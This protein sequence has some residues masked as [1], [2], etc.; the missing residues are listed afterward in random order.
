MLTELEQLLNWPIEVPLMPISEL[1]GY[2][3]TPL[4]GWVA[5]TDH[6]V[7]ESAVIH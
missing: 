5:V 7:A 2:D 4:P 1:F 6:L 3:L